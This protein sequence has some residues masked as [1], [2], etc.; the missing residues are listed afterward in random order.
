MTTGIKELYLEITEFLSRSGGSYTSIDTATYRDIIDALL[1]KRYRITRDESGNITAFT[2]WW[3]IHESDI[4]AVIHGGRPD[5]L[6][7][8]TIVYVADHAGPSGYPELIRFI[9]TTIGK[10]GVCWH[11]RYKQPSQFRHF[12]EKRGTHV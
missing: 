4:D 7:T 6:S 2:S 9:R 3:M 8:G 5:D 12:P 11:H 10:K 1:D